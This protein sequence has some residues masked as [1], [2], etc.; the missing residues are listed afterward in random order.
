[1][2]YSWSKSILRNVWAEGIVGIR[3]ALKKK[4]HLHCLFLCLILA[5]RKEV[6][7]HLL[8]FG[9]MTL[10]NKH[11]PDSSYQSLQAHCYVRPERH[12]SAAPKYKSLTSERK[13]QNNSNKIPS[14]C[15]VFSMCFSK[16]NCKYFIY[17]LRNTQ[18]IYIMWNR[19]W[20]NAACK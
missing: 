13:T 15:V 11:Y 2:K 5:L 1:M 6:E 8:S 19:G 3:G 20:Y 14:K 4:Q 9:K 17:T 7:K 16:M 18:N 12:V 10:L